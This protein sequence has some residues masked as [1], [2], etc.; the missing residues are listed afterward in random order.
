VQVAGALTGSVTTTNRSIAAPM[1]RGSY[2]ITVVAT[3]ACGGSAGTAAPAV[4][5]P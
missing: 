2:T 4:T 3:N 1:P 5:V